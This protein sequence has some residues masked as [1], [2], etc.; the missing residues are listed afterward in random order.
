MGTPDFAVPTLKAL[1]KT[2]FPIALVITQPDRPKGRGRK[3][4]SSPVKKAALELGCEISQ[5]ANVREPWFIDQLKAL[6]PDYLVVAA[7]GQI[8]PLTILK[9]PKRGAINVHASLLPKYRGPA[10]IQWAI[11]RGE[12]ETGITTMLMDNGVDTGDMLLT[13]RTPI[14]STDTAKSLHDRLAL[15]GAD[16]LVETLHMLWQGKLFPRS[17]T[18]EH[19]T[20]APMLKKEDGHLDWHKT[21]R[22]LDAFV[23]AMTP[24][25]GAFCFQDH[26]RLRVFRVM[27]LDHPA[28]EPPGTVEPGFPDEL[29]I[30]TGDGVLLILEIQGASGK[31]M[32]VRDYLCG[33]P[34]LP[35]TQLT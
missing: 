7:F 28:S 8:L 19:A 27:A 35:G 33:H 25:P 22:Q 31:R 3:M 17:Q 30:A 6:S 21:A 1:N 4:A 18:H 23:R 12:T 15:M 2:G 13:A 5:P 14:E 26:R 11:I 24:W 9:I 16:L 34:M 32:D 29:R 10:P 20:Y